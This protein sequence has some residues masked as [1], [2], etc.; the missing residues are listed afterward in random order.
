MSKNVLVVDD[1]AFY[2]EIL[3]RILNGGGFTVVGEAE[4]GDDAV[5]KFSEL[6]PDLVTMDLVMP[7]KGG[8]EAAQEI[9]RNNP[10]ALVVMCSA[11][12]QDT[13]VM[14]A[15]EAG[16]ADFITK[17]SRPDEVLSVVNKVLRVG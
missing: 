6:Q 13:M 16:A 17:P 1:S 15:L 10:K 2:R 4:N 12:G 14:E 8:V 11:L 9:M 7:G 3:K 5:K